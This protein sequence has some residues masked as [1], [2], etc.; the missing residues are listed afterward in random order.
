MLR[1]TL[2]YYV[3]VLRRR[4]MPAFSALSERTLKKTFC[5]QSGCQS[6]EAYEVE[7]ENVDLCATISTANLA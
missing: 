2:A 4:I 7:G 1:I 5:E 6:Y 3:G